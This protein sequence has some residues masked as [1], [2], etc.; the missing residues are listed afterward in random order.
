VASKKRDGFFKQRGSRFWSCRDPVTGKR[1]STGF[2]DKAAAK[3]WRAQRERIAADP[4]TA[5]TEAAELGEWVQNFLA[6][7]ERTVSAAT[8][9]VAQQKLGHFV[10]LWGADF[11]LAVLTPSVFD[12]YVA[13]RR[14]ENV[15]DHTITKEWVHLRGVL[16]LAKRGG[17]YPGDIEAL[18]P[19]D[20]HAGYKPRT[21]ALTRPEL[22]A[23]LTVL[24]PGHMA[25]VCVMVSLG[26]RKAE[27]ERLLPSDISATEV[28]IRGTKTAGSM[29]TV[30]ILS[31]YR[32]LLEMARPHLPLPPWPGAHK[33]LAWACKRA[34][35][36]YC[37]PNDFRRT[38]ATL[39]HESGVDRDVIR[40]LLGHT[41]TAMVDKVYGQP[42]PEAL[43]DL[44]EAKLLTAKVLIES[45]SERFRRVSWEW[46]QKGKVA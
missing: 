46:F 20:L 2:K 33:S 22:G 1:V 14:T 4:A 29:R 24:E 18:R 43:R 6:L 28:L 25:W 11:R 15:T 32:P 30:P 3:L 31:L 21:R 10:R 17:A 44:A 38:H 12:D 19:L 16:R 5:K 26:L 39:L 23:L 41:S 40:R 9:E 42:K 13:Q 37:S 35:I 7:K 27:A 45:P 8:L 34:G 36:D